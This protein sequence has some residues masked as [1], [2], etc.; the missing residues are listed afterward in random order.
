MMKQLLY[1]TSISLLLSC[2]AGRQSQKQSSDTLN[3]V[4]S[5][6]KQKQF[7]A[8]RDLFSSAFHSFSRVYQL[9]I[10]AE[11]DNV[12]N[13][14]Q[15]SNTKIDT[16]LADFSGELSVADKY[17]LYRLKQMN[18]SKLFEYAAADRAVLELL[19]TYSNLMTPEEIKDFQNTRKI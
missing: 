16:L 6:L 8:A 13:R 10:G 7:F 15:E 14:L 19:S 11:L 17:H 9:K 5:L 3:Q 18:H 2:N 4:D 12:F 1:V